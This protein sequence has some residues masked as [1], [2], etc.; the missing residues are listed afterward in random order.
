MGISQKEAKFHVPFR[1]CNRVSV[2]A[3]WEGSEK[4]QRQKEVQLGVEFLIFT[5]NTQ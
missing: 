1:L 4:G 5:V 3:S 2:I